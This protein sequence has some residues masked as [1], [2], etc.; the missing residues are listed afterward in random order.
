MNKTDL[1]AAVAADTNLTKAECTRALESAL[2]HLTNSLMRGEEVHLQGFGAF[3]VSNRRQRTGRN[4]RS[5]E[6]VIIKACK[7]AK[8]AAG[9]ALKEALNPIGDPA[10]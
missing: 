7:T 1:V 8:F 5:G 10:T 2:A 9:K 6:P 4:P 3:G